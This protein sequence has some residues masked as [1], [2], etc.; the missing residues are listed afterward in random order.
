MKYMDIYF[1]KYVQSVQFSH[2]V[3]SDSLQ[4]HESQNTST[5]HNIYIYICNGWK[6]LAIYI[7]TGLPWWLSWYKICLQCWRPGFNPWVRKIPWRREWLTISVFLP[8]EFHGQKRL[9][10]YSHEDIYK[11]SSRQQV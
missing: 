7:F 9:A 10:D 4:P 11:F 6:A 1:Y 5:L 8:E 3:V 2:S